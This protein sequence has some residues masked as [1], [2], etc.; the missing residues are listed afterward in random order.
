M[1]D[2]PWPLIENIESMVVKGPNEM[3]DGS[4]LIGD[5]ASKAPEII[6]GMP[7]TQK[8]DCWSFGILIFF[9]LT[10]EHP[11]GPIT[12][13]SDLEDAIVNGFAKIERLM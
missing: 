12:D 2:L 3:T 6:L 11:F 9:M 4:D 8:A 1:A 5:V 7:Y 10:Q 13:Q